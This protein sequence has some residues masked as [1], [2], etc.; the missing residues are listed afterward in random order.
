MASSVV[1]PQRHEKRLFAEPPDL[2]AA[3]LFRGAEDSEV[4]ADTVEDP[5]RGPAN[6]LDPVVVGRDAVHEV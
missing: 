2:V 1:V 6:R 3:V 5:R 4:L